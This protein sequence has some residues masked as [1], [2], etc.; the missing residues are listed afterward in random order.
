M[1]RG[2]TVRETM[3]NGN[4]ELYYTLKGE[5][6]R[7]YLSL[8]L[9]ELF[10]PGLFPFVSLVDILMRRNSHRQGVELQRQRPVWH[11]QS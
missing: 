4:A 3:L 11:L 5:D 1:C 9:P 8:L 10:R 2:D 7:L 6:Q